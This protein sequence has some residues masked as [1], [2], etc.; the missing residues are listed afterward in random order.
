VQTGTGILV[1]HIK[2]YRHLQVGHFIEN[3]KNERKK[4]RSKILGK[5]RLG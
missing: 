1:K 4:N 5:V 2:V 3:V